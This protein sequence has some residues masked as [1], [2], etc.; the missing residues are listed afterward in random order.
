[1]DSG[2]IFRKKERLRGDRQLEHR[3]T[4]GG[5]VVKQPG[6][7][8]ANDREEQGDCV[9]EKVEMNSWQHLRLCVCN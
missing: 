2:Y 3:F 1:M 5:K 8:T 4:E 9:M 7:G 6:D